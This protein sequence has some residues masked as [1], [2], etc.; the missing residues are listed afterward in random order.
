MTIRS[1]ILHANPIGKE[2]DAFRDTHA[3]DPIEAGNREGI[4]RP[5]LCTDR[6]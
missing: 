3:L 1:E 6:L 2:L 5:K 4:V